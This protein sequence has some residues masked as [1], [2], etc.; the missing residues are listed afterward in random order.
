MGGRRRAP[1]PPVW[2]GD[3]WAPLAAPPLPAGFAAKPA[4]SLG[5]RDGLEA[6]GAA[7]GQ[8]AV[9]ATAE[10]AAGGVSQSARDL[11]PALLELPGR[12]SRRG[13]QL[14]T[15]GDRRR[16]R[17]GTSSRRPKLAAR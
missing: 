15:L 12:H 2:D 3:G 6:G 13:D 4:A 8:R 9:E 11:L 14:R 5:E 17:G 10:R 7:I 1:H 16:A